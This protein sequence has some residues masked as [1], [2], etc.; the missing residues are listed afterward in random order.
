MGRY[1]E[2]YIHTILH[3]T[4]YLYTSLMSTSNTSASDMSTYS[5]QLFHYQDLNG[6]GCKS[7]R[8]LGGKTT[9]DLNMKTNDKQTSVYLDDLK[10][11][12]WYNKIAE[13][14]SDR[15]RDRSSQTIS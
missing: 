2:V 15:A 13:L 8:P 14:K 9:R 10:I 4:I 12:V 6:L 5:E 7:Q 1:V 11:S 3:Y